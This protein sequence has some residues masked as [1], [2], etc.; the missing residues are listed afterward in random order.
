MIELQDVAVRYAGPRGGEPV[1]A[2]SGI[3]FILDEGLVALAGRSGSGKTTILNVAAGLLQPS[4]GLVLWDGRRLDDLRDSERS[5]QRRRN[6]GFVFQGAG[7]IPS[8]TALENV[9]A[10]GYR[11]ADFQNG[12]AKAAQLLRRMGLADRMHHMP[13]ELSGGERQRVGIAR[14]LL[15]S[16]AHLLV[17]EPTANLD[18][19]AATAVVTMLQ[20]LAAEHRGILV[21]SHDQQLVEAAG[22]VISLT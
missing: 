17:D 3:S 4:A 6:I 7:L 1:K 21:A 8:L 18:G 15:L 9:A 5:E 19:I 16:P 13:G 22:R 14:A 2:I 10:P 11:L 12:E 20:E